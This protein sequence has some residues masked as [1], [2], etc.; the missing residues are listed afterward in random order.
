MFPTSNCACHGARPADWCGT[1]H[2]RQD[3]SATCLRSKWYQR[4]PQFGK[5]AELTILE[6]A[7]DFAS[8]RTVAYLAG[9]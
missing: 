2:G 6:Q 4:D 8:R 1:G 7:K 3:A 5:G 9:H